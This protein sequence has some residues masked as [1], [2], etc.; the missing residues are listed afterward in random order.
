MNIPFDLHELSTQK[1]NVMPLVFRGLY[2]LDD[3]N[4]YDIYFLYSVLYS[5][6][7][8]KGPTGQLRSAQEWYQWIGLSNFNFDLEI[9]KKSSKF[10]SASRPNLSNYLIINGSGRLAGVR[11][12]LC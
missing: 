12:Q 4:F 11:R 10:Y 8:F 9:F 6:I 3:S 1:S 5:I 7:L 2:I